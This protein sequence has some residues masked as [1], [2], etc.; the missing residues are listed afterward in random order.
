MPF[1]NSGN[2]YPPGGWKT[3]EQK[4]QEKLSIDESRFGSMGKVILP[5]EKVVQHMRESKYDAE[6]EMLGLETPQSIET[7]AGLYHNQ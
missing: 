4:L 7:L 1:D 2:W 3:P 6:R 5:S